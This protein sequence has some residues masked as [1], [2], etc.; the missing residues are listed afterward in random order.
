MPPPSYTPP[1]VSEFTS[2]ICPVFPSPAA[3][4]AQGCNDAKSRET[5]PVT[6]FRPPASELAVSRMLVPKQCPF[7]CLIDCSTRTVCL[8]LSFWAI[9]VH[10]TVVSGFPDARHLDLHSLPLHMGENHLTFPTLT[11]QTQVSERR[12]A[13]GRGE[14][15]LP[16]DCGHQGSWALRWC[17]LVGYDIR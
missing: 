11:P 12:T 10:V 3:S 17:L 9:H 4:A 1:F 8:L 14:S 13:S 2:H 7:V 5:S 16:M 6:D 15:S